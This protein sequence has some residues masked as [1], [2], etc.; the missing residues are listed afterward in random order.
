MLEPFSGKNEFSLEVG[1]GEQKIVI[2]KRTERQS[3]YK[4]SYFSCVTF[5][6]EHYI[7]EA[8]SKGKK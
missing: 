8:K 6:D 1:P 4:V 5:P 7:A 3:S 2:L